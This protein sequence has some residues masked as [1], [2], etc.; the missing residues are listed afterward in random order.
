VV[1]A[2]ATRVARKPRSPRHPFTVAPRPYQIQPFFIAPVLPGET[3]KKGIIQTRAVTDPIAAPLVGWWLEH[4]VFYVPFEAL[5]SVADLK[6]MV[7]NPTVQ[8]AT[9]AS[10]I[11][12]HLY[13]FEGGFP[14]VK[15]CLDAVVKNYFRAN[16]DPIYGAFPGAGAGSVTADIDGVPIAT[17]ATHEDFMQSYQHEDTFSDTLDPTGR[18]GE[19]LDQYRELYEVWK[20]AGF[21]K[22]T[23]EQFLEQYGVHIP[24]SEKENIPEL[25]RYSR[26]WQYP[27]NTVNAA[28]GTVAS[29]V[30]WSINLTIDKDRFFKQPGF[31][32]GVTLSRPKVYLN[33]Q[34]GSAT[35]MLRD[36]LKWMPSALLDDPSTSLAQF[37]GGTSE[38][39]VIGGG[40]LGAYVYDGY[41]LDVRDLFRYGEQFIGQF[42]G[43]AVDDASR[44]ILY[45]MDPSHARRFM[46][47]ENI[48][49]LFKDPLV[50]KRVRQDGIVQ[51]NVATHP[52]LSTRGDATPPGI[53]T[54]G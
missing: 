42:P 16:G 1:A 29:A 25:V 19:N 21:Q 2:E 31:I 46:K 38:G 13:Q 12:P 4:F 53:T 54:T 28:N 11:E 43:A 22:L 40:P 49:K 50:G 9:V 3:L 32:F 8:L 37:M 6:A 26:D 51:L 18:G 48:D 5:A 15:E 52:L 47:P 20:S 14:F 17:A 41:W 24:S 23:Y 10:G 7:L 45:S 36:A 33:T 35:G 39:G 34:L 30:S 27:S 44:S